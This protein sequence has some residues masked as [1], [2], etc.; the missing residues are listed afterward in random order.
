MPAYYPRF[1]AW[2]ERYFHL[3][4][5]DEPR[6]VGGIFYDDLN[7]RRLGG[8]FRLHPATWAAPFLDGLSPASFAAA[9]ER[10]LDRGAARPTCSRGAGRYV[11]FNLLHDRGTRFGLETGG[12]AEA[13]L[14]SLPARGCAGPER[15]ARGRAGR[16]PAAAAAA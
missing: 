6:G 1:K 8:R 7:S 12:N 4:H 13:I 2:C 16:L 14:M 15:H 10:A 5:R 3:A 9:W 11:E